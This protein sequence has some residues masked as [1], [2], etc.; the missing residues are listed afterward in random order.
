MRVMV[1]GHRGYIGSVMCELLKEQGHFVIGVDHNPEMKPVDLM[2]DL[3]SSA[4]FADYPVAQSVVS[5]N[6]DCIFHFAASASVSDSVANPAQYYINNTGNT[7]TLLGYLHRL[8][9]KGK[10]IF[11]STA[12]VY[13]NEFNT[14]IAEDYEKTPCNPYGLSK[15][16]CEQL[17]TDVCTKAGIDAVMFRYFNVAGAYNNTG[18]HLT[19]GHIIPMICDSVYNDKQF[20]IFGN[21][22][23][24]PDG[25]CIRDYVHVLDI[26]RA[27]LHAAEWNEPGVHVFNL[28]SSSGFSN[29][30]IVDAFETPV[31]YVYG[32][33]RPGDPDTLIADNRKF[34]SKTG[35]EYKHTNLKDIISSSWAWHNKLMKRNS[36]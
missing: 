30:E 21:D 4:N 6:I 7:A 31:S 22:Y 36:E 10:F 20:T 14:P 9:W 35:F 33:R 8:G 24:T 23:S 18:D 26:C 19:S 27:H 29:K 13:G 15:L 1:T 11:S 3:N 28:G 34:I 16:M 5:N 32:D 17:I 12:A 25:T 2:I